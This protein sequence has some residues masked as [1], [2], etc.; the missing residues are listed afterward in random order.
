M[1]ETPS[2]YNIDYSTIHIWPNNWGWIDKTD[3]PGTLDKAIENTREYIDVHIA[4][5]QKMNKPLVLEEFGLPRDCV[6]FDRKSS[7]AL[8]DGIMEKFLK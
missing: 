2:G 1:G 5:A 7:T 3:I 6:M 8:R 4:E